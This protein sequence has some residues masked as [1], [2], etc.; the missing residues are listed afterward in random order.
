MVHAITEANEVRTGHRMSTIG[1][2][3][4]LAK[5]LD[6]VEAPPSGQSAFQKALAE[7]KSRENNTNA[8]GTPVVGVLKE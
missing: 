8:D 4:Y 3:N 5:K 2:V 6:T 1:S 7:A